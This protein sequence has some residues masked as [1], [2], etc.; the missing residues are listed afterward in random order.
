MCVFMF[1]YIHVY[2]HTH[3]HTREG[4][5]Y[6]HLKAQS[7]KVS[8]VWPHLL[9]SQTTLQSTARS[10]GELTWF[11]SCCWRSSSASTSQPSASTSPILRRTASYGALRRY[12]RIAPYVFMHI[13]PWSCTL[14]SEAPYIAFVPDATCISCQALGMDRGL[15]SCEFK[16]R[17]RI[18][19]SISP[20]GAS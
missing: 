3:T 14:N 15:N 1:T 16:P 10:A 17:A 9:V 12:L 2:A 19:R 18:L 6:F 11:S 13:L 20:R 7:A 4:L 8:G 5:Q